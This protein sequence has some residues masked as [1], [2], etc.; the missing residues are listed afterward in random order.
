MFNQQFKTWTTYIKLVF[1]LLLHVIFRHLKDEVRLPSE[2]LAFPECTSASAGSEGEKKEETE[3][4][5]Q[6]QLK[7]KGPNK[8]RLACM[9]V[10]FWH[11]I[12]VCVCLICWCWTYLWSHP[13]IRNQTHPTQPLGKAVIFQPNLDPLGPAWSLDL[14]PRYVAYL[15]INLQLEPELSWVARVSWHRF[16]ATELPPVGHPDKVVKSE[17]ILSKMA[18]TFR[19]RIYNPDTVVRIEYWMWCWLWKNSHG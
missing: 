19:L 12:V 4:K 13:R 6:K 17:G 3:E 9:W 15:G 16:R 2:R 8:V 11:A 5:R 14:S 1:L 7:K 18:E 10:S